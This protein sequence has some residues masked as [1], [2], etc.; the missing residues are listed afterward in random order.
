V[1]EEVKER[2]TEKQRC[3]EIRSSGEIKK[4]IIPVT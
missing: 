4:R 2:E 1:E 3:Q